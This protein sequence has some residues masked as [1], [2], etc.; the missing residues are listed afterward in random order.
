MREDS[1]REGPAFRPDAVRHRKGFHFLSFADTVS[2]SSWRAV[3]RLY[4]QLNGGPA[5]VTPLDGQR[6]VLPL[7]PPQM[8]RGVIGLLLALPWLII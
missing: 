6:C 7:Q 2:I 4:D 8:E 5:L 1:C 3:T